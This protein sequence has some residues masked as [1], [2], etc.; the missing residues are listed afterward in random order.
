MKNK[1]KKCITHFIIYSNL[2]KIYT[3]IN[4]LIRIIYTR[5]HTR[6]WI[7]SEL[8]GNPTSGVVLCLTL[9]HAT[10]LLLIHLFLSLTH[11]KV[12]LL[13]S[14]KTQQPQRWAPPT[15]VLSIGPVIRPAA[16]ILTVI[17]MLLVPAIRILNKL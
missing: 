15:Q 11:N 5:S 13:L 3:Y 17:F 1:R 12:L 4:Q 16:V 8:A 6:I 14:H 10:Y 9:R 2:F 7:I